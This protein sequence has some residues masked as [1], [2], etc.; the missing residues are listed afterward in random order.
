M[1]FTAAQLAELI[2]GEVVGDG[3]VSLTGFAPAGA[4]RPG[5][6][7][8]AENEAYF[9]RAEQSAARAVLVDGSFT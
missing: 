3:S 8:F 5:D 7:T 1:P 6:L 9:A 2:Q 4:A